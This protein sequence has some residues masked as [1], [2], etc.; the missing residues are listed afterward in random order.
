VG[1][2]PMYVPLV[3]T[4]VFWAMYKQWCSHGDMPRESAEC[5]YLPFE[6]NR[7]SIRRRTLPLRCRPAS[8]ELA[9]A[10]LMML[11]NRVPLYPPTVE[12]GNQRYP[13]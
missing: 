8:A 7:S 6:G 10:R 3:Q 1:I 2:T 13:R 12:S 9:A 4:L 11:T 5:S